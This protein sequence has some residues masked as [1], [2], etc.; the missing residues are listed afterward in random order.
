MK[1]IF[2]ILFFIPLLGY[3]SELYDIRKLDNDIILLRFSDRVEYQSKLSDDK[4]NIFITIANATNKSNL[5]NKKIKSD[6]LKEVFI[7]N[8]KNNLLVNVILNSN[9]GFNTYQLPYSNSLII[10]V[11]DW[12]KLTKSE[13]QFR[14]GL[15]AYESSLYNQ[16]ILL[17]NDAK[18]EVTDAQ[19]LLGIVYLLEDSLELS[20]RQLTEAARRQTYIPD[21]YAALSQMYKEKGNNT[22][23]K[24]YEDQFLLKLGIKDST[25]EYPKLIFDKAKLANIE[26]EESIDSTGLFDDSDLEAVRFSNLFDKK[27]SKETSQSRNKEK[28]L[29]NDAFLDMK[30]FLKYIIIAFVLLILFVISIYL[31]WRNNKINNQNKTAK[32]DF[33]QE[34]KDVIRQEKTKSSIIIDRTDDEIIP[35]KSDLI[36]NT[37]NDN[38]GSLTYDRNLKI[39][40]SDKKI[41]GKE[42]LN[43]ISDNPEA[44]NL[45]TLSNKLD[46]N[47]QK[48]KLYSKF[49]VDKR[50][51]Q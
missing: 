3:S 40:S 11:F 4:K 7:K 20:L 33:E 22:K 25:F 37:A 12:N 38:T 24:Y 13:D 47:V 5:N 41:E 9:S 15:F 36:D 31:K 2:F 16:S 39:E 34:L 46:N 6:L 43:K 32:K 23:A 50:T 28:I 30:G 35:T 10:D 51:N 42:L 44:P 8:D 45:S 26:I 21:V 19:S 18:L 27:G 48:S 14:S 49:N 17:F 29:E 1:L